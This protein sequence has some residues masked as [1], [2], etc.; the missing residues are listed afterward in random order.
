MAN[1]YQIRR[2]I[3]EALKEYNPTPCNVES[4]QDF[5]KF[6]LLQAENEEIRTQWKELKAFGYIEAIPGF[7]GK[8]CRITEKGLK[9]VNPEFAKEPFV[10]GPM[11]L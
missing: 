10:W 5:P 9:Q 8:Y 6:A 2:Y 1:I 7:E 11:S 4:V 3:L